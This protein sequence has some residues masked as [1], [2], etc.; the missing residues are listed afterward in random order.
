MYKPLNFNKA[1]PM[2]IQDDSSYVDDECRTDERPS[3]NLPNNSAVSGTGRKQGRFKKDNG[4]RTSPF[5][6]HA[7]AKIIFD[8]N[9]ASPSRPS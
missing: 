3:F 5:K 6:Y 8:R 4:M 2:K 1:A 9:S 7:R